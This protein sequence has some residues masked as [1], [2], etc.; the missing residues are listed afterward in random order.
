MA[1]TYSTDLR[2]ELIG[3]GEQSGVWGSTTNLNLGSLIEQAVA[4][5]EAISITSANQALVAF[6]GAVDEA[7]NAVLVLSSSAAANVY[8]PPVNKVYVV[9][10]A[11]SYAITMYNSTV[12]GNTTAAGAG[13]TVA[14]GTTTNMFT[15]GANFYASA[16]PTGSTT[17]TGSVVY[18]VSPALTGTPT[19]PTATAGTNTTQIAT[20][21][22]VQNVAGGL[23]TMSTQNANAVAITGGTVAGITGSINSVTPGSNAAGARTVSTSSPTG[24]SD[25]DIWYKV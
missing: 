25:G 19:A 10:N 16:L 22:F 14:A 17:G 3:S 13:I 6:Y 9:R 20:T 15:D 18:S 4:G 7:R 1:S 5:V 23:G 21:A 8:V 2:L 12:L 11:G 24:G